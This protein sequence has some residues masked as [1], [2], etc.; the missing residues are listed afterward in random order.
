MDWYAL[1]DHA[2]PDTGVRWRAG[3]E[4]LPGRNRA[5]R[6]WYPALGD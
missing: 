1:T 2:D 6:V 5:T 4:T 3:F